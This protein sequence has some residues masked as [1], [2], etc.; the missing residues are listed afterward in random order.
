MQ[1]EQHHAHRLTADLIKLELESLSDSIFDLNEAIRYV[2]VL[3]SSNCLLESRSK[4]SGINGIPIERWREF[5]SFGPL[6]VL[7]SMERLEPHSGRLEFLVARYE[8]H[9]LAIC[10]LQNHFVVLA[11]DSKTEIQVA[12]SICNR[13]SVLLYEHGVH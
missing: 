2:A 10:H 12:E 1:R 4:D 6:M 11:L 9:L 7:G 3:D 5:V 13:V 8:K